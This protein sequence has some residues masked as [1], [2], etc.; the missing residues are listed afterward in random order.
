MSDDPLADLLDRAQHDLEREPEHHDDHLADW[1]RAH[2][3]EVLDALGGRRLVHVDRS[4][5]FPESDFR[6]VPGTSAHYKIITA[7]HHALRS[8]DLER[9]FN[10]LL[11]TDPRWRLRHTI[12]VP[13]QPAKFPSYA[14][15]G[16]Y[17]F[18]YPPYVVF[19]FELDE[20]DHDE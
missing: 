5:W 18:G 6:W 4:W 7:E 17:Y 3:D 15:G 10:E 14:T 8:G 9:E 16:T 2:L 11:A 19:V 1:M 20:S 12:A 13:G